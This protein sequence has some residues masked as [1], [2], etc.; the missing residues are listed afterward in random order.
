M[1][2]EERKTEILKLIKSGT[3][4]RVGELTQNFGISESTVR[5]D[6][7][8][9]EDAGLIQRTHGGAILAQLGYELTFHEKGVRLL[10]E[11]QKIAQLAADLVEEGETVLLDAGTTT[12]EIA[13]ALQGKRITVATNSIEVAQIFAEDADV[14]VLILGG[15]WRKSTRS[16]VGYLTNEML[17]RIHFDKV[18]LAAN[19]VEA[20][21]GVTT[22]NSMEAE[23]KRHMVQAGKKIILVVDHS[24][25][26]QKG[27]Y[28]ICD[29]GEID[30]LIIDD[31]LDDEELAM[32]RSNTQ[33]IV[34]GE[35]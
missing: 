32:L 23:T 35:K 30:L 29:L 5:R 3:P 11:K 2:P 27:L 19:G 17:R 34:A 33:V 21:L 28:K 14:E 10:K 7:Q 18:F 20:N 22:P 12:L 13:R 25:I 8:E 16:L 1:F 24:K 9:M 26:G 31:Q 4:V 15:T 6:L